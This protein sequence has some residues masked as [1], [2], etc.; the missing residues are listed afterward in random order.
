M[1][2][3]PKIA[4]DFQELLTEISVSYPWFIMP[5]VIR[6]SLCDKLDRKRS[7][8]ESV[9][10][11][12]YANNYYPLQSA[13][14]CTN[15]TKNYLFLEK[16]EDVSFVKPSDEEITNGAVIYESNWTENDIFP[17]GR[18][19][20]TPSGLFYSEETEGY[21]I[22]KEVI[23]VNQK[24]NDAGEKIS[25]DKTA[26][27]IDLFLDKKIGRITPQIGD[28]KDTTVDLSIVETDE[29]ITE[30]MAK[31]YRMQGLNNE[32][33]SIYNKLSLKYPEKF[34]YFAEIIS[35]I[36]TDEEKETKK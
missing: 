35:S 29:I 8:I 31:I 5:K 2:A 7:I 15:Y 16:K 27:I 9:S 28:N 22:I 19:V 3:N 34:R 18:I 12:F 36:K 4:V 25:I 33:I 30:S 1:I 20:V 14:V 17:K 32:A 24:I 21:R 13:S 10:I 6:L 26:E 11:N 23:A